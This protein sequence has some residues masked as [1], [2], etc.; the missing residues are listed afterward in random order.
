MQISEHVFR[1]E[2]SCHVYVLVTGTDAVLIDIG[3]GDVLEQLAQFGVRRVT[4]VLLTHHHR[5]QTQGLPRAVELGARIWVPPVEVDLVA[6]VDEHWQQR[7]VDN[8]Y[9]LRQ[10][11]FSLIS[12]VPVHATSPEYRTVTIGGFA[13]RTIATPGHTIGSVS[14][15]VEVDDT[16]LAFTGDLLYGPGKVWSL[17]ATQWTYTGHEGLAS[18]V[19]SLHE[20]LD[21]AP[22]LVLPSHGNPMDDFPFA[23]AATEPNLRALLDMGR[24]VPWDLRAWRDRPFQVLSPHLLRNRTANAQS[25]VLLSETG[26][27]LLIDFGYDMDTGWPA[28]QDRAARRVWLPSLRSL[29]RDFG[30]DR[31]EVAIP[32]HYHDDHV[33]GLN[34]LRE[35]ESTQIWCEPDMAAILADPMR[36]DLPCLYADA[37][38]TDRLLPTGQP[39]SWREYELQLHPLPGHCAQQVAI[40]FEVDGLRVLATGDQQESLWED[41]HRPEVLNYQYKNGFR[42]ADY[43]AAA[44]LYRTLRPDL[45]LTGHWGVRRVDDAYLDEMLRQSE[46]LVELHRALLPGDRVDF[47]ANEFSAVILPYRASSMP[48]HGMVFD[49]VVTNPQPVRAH[50]EVSMIVPPDWSVEPTGH[51]IELDSGAAGVIGFLVVSPPDVGP[52]R[53]VVLAADVTVGGRRIGQQAECLVDLR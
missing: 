50:C 9:N 47:A 41:G 51:D 28:G 18:T 5:D 38:A 19:I 4:D 27:A 29:K 21:E 26:G 17:A 36:F 45:I 14:Y 23:V 24:A 49:V 30:V 31:V 32:T 37:V 16:R 25:Y 42:P 7:S 8:Y 11:R 43:V 1:F 13:V 10:D 34:L 15:L 12:P 40:E 53:R 3:T 2:D 39:F 33:A 44:H 46:Q 35:V 22:D 48:G 52:Q 20:V 6:A